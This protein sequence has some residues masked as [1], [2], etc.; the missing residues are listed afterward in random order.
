MINISARNVPRAYL[1][2]LTHMRISGIEEYSRAGPVLTIPDP[3][4]LTIYDPKERVLFDPLR[5]ANP[6]FHLMEAIWM[7]AGENDASWLFPFNRKF[8][9]FTE[10]DRR[11]RGAYGYRWR[12]H[13]GIDQLIH[14][15]KMLRDDP[16][17][18]RAVLTMWDPGY[19][20]HQGYNDYPCNTHIYF[21]VNVINDELDMLVCNR[22]NDLV[23]GMLGSNAVHMTMLQ[24]VMAYASGHKLGQYRVITN[25]LHVYKDLPNYDKIINTNVRYDLYDHVS[26]M[27]IYEA[28]DLQEFLI[29]CR[30]FI[31]GAFEAVMSP[32]LRLVAKPM[33][34]A[35][36]DRKLG[37]DSGLTALGKMRSNNDWRIAGEQWIQR[38][39]KTS[40]SST[41][42]EPSPLMITEPTL[43]N[44]ESPDDGTNTLTSAKET[45]PITP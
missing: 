16:T 4:M 31:S 33:Y 42:T 2:A 17:T 14:L 15:A 12:Y 21:R 36:N 41:S 3:V 7:F 8:E 32:F 18:R 30:A 5:N 43:Y 20:L 37:R 23:W 28:S 10:F 44:P 26:A 19:D 27:P 40:S 11:L 38:H 6:F 34:D 9:Q 29:D 22:S 35:Y 45:P 13:F 24:E 25:N 1:E 39:E